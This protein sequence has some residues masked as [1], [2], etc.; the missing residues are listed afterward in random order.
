MDPFL[1]CLIPP[2]LAAYYVVVWLRTRR[3]V[4]SGNIVVR[5]QP[6]EGLSPAAIRYITTF[7]CDGRTWVAILARLAAYKLLSIT[8]DKNKGTVYLHKLQEDRHLAAKLA[9]EERIVFRSLFEWEKNIALGAPEPRLM[10]KIK[11][12][13]QAQLRSYVTRNIPYVVAALVLSGLATI[14]MCLSLRLFG[15]DPVETIVISA[16]TGLTVATFSAAAIYFWDANLQAVRLAF[17][18]LYHRRVLLFLLFL[19]LLFPALWY[20]LLRTVAPAFA[21]VT[22][23]MILI[24]MF[25]APGMRSCTPGGRKVLNQIHGFREFL[26]SAEQDRLQQL[27]LPGET[28]LAGHEYLPYAIALDIKEDWGD[29]LGIKAMVETQL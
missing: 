16:F 14:W 3:K 27:N 11:K 9:E 8:V 4:P 29:E 6:P 19:V 28:V 12:T 25:A 2:A 13:L 15:D 10:E 17:R 7:G 1:F 23:L 22:G 5:Y 21:N 24:N 20:F 26:Q 18:G